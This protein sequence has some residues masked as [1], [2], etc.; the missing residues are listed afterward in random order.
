MSK[1]YYPITACLQKTE[2]ENSDSVAVDMSGQ[3]QQGQSASF[4]T[5]GSQECS[6]SADASSQGWIQRVSSGV[7]NA[8]VSGAK[9]V[10]STTYS[11]GSGVVSAGSNVARKFVR[12][13]KDKNE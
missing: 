8:G 5:R 10:A 7:Y 1:L 11:V 13:P 4:T 3:D 12:K 2:K 9:L 6:S